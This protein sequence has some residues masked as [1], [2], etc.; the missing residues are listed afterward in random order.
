MHSD[1]AASTAAEAA[2]E[3]GHSGVRSF[4][5]QQKKERCGEKDAGFTKPWAA[6]KK[7]KGKRKALKAGT[8]D[9][10]LH[11]NTTPSTRGTE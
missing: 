4:G 9:Q 7:L 11:R 2:C 8:S 5:G 6:I 10:N 1:E 3:Q